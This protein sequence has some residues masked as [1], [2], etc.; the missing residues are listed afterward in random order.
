MG[1]CRDKSV[2]S[3]GASRGITSQP[4]SASVRARDASDTIILD[5]HVN[6]IYGK[7]KNENTSSSIII[8]RFSQ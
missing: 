5:G 3:G 2:V 6:I 4:V 8:P 1:R 7:D